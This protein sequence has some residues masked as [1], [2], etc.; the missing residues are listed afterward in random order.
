MPNFVPVFQARKGLSIFIFGVVTMG[1]ALAV[2]VLSNLFFKS[3]FMTEFIWNV[4]TFRGMFVRLPDHLPKDNVLSA[5][6]IAFKD[7]YAHDI[8]SVAENAF[9]YSVFTSGVC[10]LGLIS[11]FAQTFLEPGRFARRFTKW[12]PYAVIGLTGI[13]I[14]LF[15]AY[16]TTGNQDMALTYIDK[17]FLA[18][19]SNIYVASDTFNYSPLWYWIVR[20]LDLISQAFPRIPF[21]FL[22][23]AFTSVI[24]LFV[25]ATVVEIAK[26]IGKSPI[27]AG[28]FFFLNPISIIISGYHGQIEG[29]I[30][31]FL[32]FA[33]YLFLKWKGRAFYPGWLLITV[34]V[35][36][37]H[38][39]FNQILVYLAHIERSWKKI[40]LLCLLSGTVFVASFAPYLLEGYKEILS[41]VIR[42]GG[43][44]R[45][46]GFGLAGLYPKVFPFYKIFFIG[47]LTLWPFL[48][49]CQSILKS[50]L[51][52]ILLFL[53]FTPGISAQ[54]FV[55]PVALAA[56]S[57]SFGFWLYTAVAS[58]FLL[59][60]IDELKI[61]AFSIVDWPFVWIVVV[62]WFAMELSSGCVFGRRAYNTA[63]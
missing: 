49:R 33:L 48:T 6:A 42:Y 41:D 56:L 51:V 34:G 11:F 13:G 29:F 4:N 7:F 22:E 5:Y 62:V 52:T 47:L 23:R 54:Q 27:K 39:I 38:L 8:R 26:L 25:F 35:T 10:A 44:V 18:S 14:R 60:N 20:C 37:K 55:L 57:P 16:H 50:S 58:L 45:T 31:M 40:L 17:E 36:I 43:V 15:F 46:Y 12:A 3:G 9:Y 21:T 2:Y 63:P 32:L 19:G 1:V 61:A 24:D 59:G 53:T 30:I 28:A